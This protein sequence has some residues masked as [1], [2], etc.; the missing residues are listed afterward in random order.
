ML[1]AADNGKLPHR[2][3]P[4]L[5][6]DYVALSLDTTISAIYRALHLFAMFPGQWEIMKGD[7][8]LI[9]NAVNGIIRYE[10]PLRAFSRKAFQDCTIS[11]VRIP[12]GARVLVIY[13]SVN[14]DEWEW[15]QP[16]VFDVRRYANRDR[17]SPSG[18]RGDAARAGRARGPDRADLAANV[19]DQQHH[20]AT[21]TVTAQ[22]GS[23][24]SGYFSSDDDKP[25]SRR[26][27]T[28]CWI[29]WVPSKMS[30]IFESRA[31]FSNSVSSE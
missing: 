22:A 2:E 27:T 8:A 28:N 24:L 6:V 7:H 12:A 31:H 15:D 18:N 26:A 14:R 5:M 30:M 13:A 4:P 25:S 17:G 10:T 29:C 1:I 3:C 21:R 19:G 23:R 20:S 16:E 11:G 9:P